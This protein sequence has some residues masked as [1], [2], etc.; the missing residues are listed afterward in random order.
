MKKRFLSAMVSLVVAVACMP[1]QFALAKND[2]A[3]VIYSNDF[4]SGA[5]SAN[6]NYETEG[7]WKLAEKAGIDAAGSGESDYAF[8]PGWVPGQDTA[9]KGWNSSFYYLPAS[10]QKTSGVYTF[11]FD[12]YLGEK[13]AENNMYLCANVSDYVTLK[14]L[15]YGVGLATKTWYSMEITADLDTDTFEFTVFSSDGSVVFSQ[16]GEYKYD[17]VQF[18]EFG[19]TASNSIAGASHVTGNASKLDNFSVIY[20]G[21]EEPV[22]PQE[23]VT[24]IPVDM[25][26][27]EGKA[28]DIVINEF[29]GANT[30]QA[31][32]TDGEDEKV[33]EIGFE[34]VEADGGSVEFA[35]FLHTSR[36]N[37]ALG[38]VAE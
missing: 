1:L 14:E 9:R 15:R 28:W 12:Y 16:T 17:I 19:V 29:N 32:F 5:I 21:V 37:V 4:E 7:G 31:V 10:E 26:D 25:D 33:G 22:V 23:P 36:A 24:I 27:Y 38:I 8:C 6:A 11:K 2:S 18:V 20:Y 3:A 34:N 13:I 35:I 30:Y